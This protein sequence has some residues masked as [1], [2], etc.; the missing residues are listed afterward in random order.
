MRSGRIGGVHVAEKITRIESLRGLGSFRDWTCEPELPKFRRYNLIYGW[1]ATGKS[2]L[3]RLLRSFELGEMPASEED[4][5]FQITCSEGTTLG[6]SELANSGLSVR[7]FSEDFVRDNLSFDDPLMPENSSVSPLLI[8]GKE[9]VDAAAKLEKLSKTLVAQRTESEKDAETY[10]RLKDNRTTL[11]I[12]GAVGIKEA[13]RSG[14]DQ[15]FHTYDKRNLEIALDKIPAKAKRPK[16]EI[17]TERK[18]MDSHLKDAID[19]SRDFDHG[20]LDR[21]RNDIAVVLATELLDTAIPELRSDEDVQEWVSRGLR[22]HVDHED[23]CLFCRQD[24]PLARMENL[25]A[26]FSDAFAAHVALIESLDTELET[27]HNEVT[28]YLKDAGKIKSDRFYDDLAGEWSTAGRDLAESSDAFLDLVV[29]SR[30]ALKTKRSD[31]FSTADDPLS[32]GIVESAVAD[33]RSVLAFVDGALLSHQERTDELDEVR[34]TAQTNIETHMIWEERSEYLDVEAQI[35][36]AKTV[37]EEMGVR[38]RQTKEEISRLESEVSGSQNACAEINTALESYF[39]HDMFAVAPSDESESLGL[40]LTRQGKPAHRLSEGERNGI[41]LVYF[42][43]KLKE[44]DLSLGK[45]IVVI[46]DPVSSLDENKAYHAYGSMIDATKPALQVVFLTH[47]FSMFR[48]LRRRL[49]GPEANKKNFRMFMTK[50]IVGETSI[51]SSLCEIDP[52]LVSHDSEY[53]FLFASLCRI[54]DADE[55]EAEDI[56]AMP[57]LGRR[58]LETFFAF[59]SP[60]GLGL[61]KKILASGIDKPKAERMIRFVNFHSHGDSTDRL[62]TLGPLGNPEAQEIARDILELMECLDP[63][64]VKEMRPASNAAGTA[65]C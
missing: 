21:L 59:K 61:D 62:E 10:G 34:I 27:L 4:F 17:E 24:M 15:R 57:N 18:R 65:G 47:N 54:A 35:S 3:A 49:G 60:S 16:I 25:R 46:D 1:N 22:L 52:N 38:L 12:K 9:N 6:P 56:Y 55:P 31:P 13:L 51:D 58:V 7:V 23:R 30:S 33:L 8:L 64:H 43:V 26:H 40:S 41:A 39:G 36:T 45:T 20:D 53:H 28:S 11:L 63:S 44:E 32:A 2:T 37:S 19:L 29:L 42:L 50:R 48:S 14:P 5:D